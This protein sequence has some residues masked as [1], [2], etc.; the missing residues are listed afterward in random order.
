MGSRLVRLLLDLIV[1]TM[2][3][4][5]VNLI[6][7][8]L[9]VWKPVAIVLAVLFIQDTLGSPRSSRRGKAPAKSEDTPC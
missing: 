6:V 1:I 4:G 9:A 7:P 8:G 5:A 3:Q 2:Q